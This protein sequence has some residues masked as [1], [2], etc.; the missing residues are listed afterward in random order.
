MA[1]APSS[2]LNRRRLNS[3]NNNN[4]RIKLRHFRQLSFAEKSRARAGTSLAESASQQRK[5]QT[6]F[7]LFPLFC[8]P[9]FRELHPTLTSISLCVLSAKKKKHMQPDSNEQRL[10]VCFL[11]SL[12]V[13]NVK[14]RS[15][16]HFF[17][18][19]RLRKKKG[20]PKKKNDM[21]TPHGQ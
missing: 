21:Q 12:L 17:K 16:E 18:K 11:V 19:K 20:S 15:S 10:S 8:R 13:F 5:K 4:K 14:R 6:V 7:L 3:N 1:A 9:C 2:L